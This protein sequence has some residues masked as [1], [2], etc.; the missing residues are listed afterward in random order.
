MIYARDPRASVYIY[1]YAPDSLAVE[2][3]RRARARA[4]ALGAVS[5]RDSTCKGSAVPPP[6]MELDHGL[7]TTGQR[8][9][10]HWEEA[11]LGG[12]LRQRDGQTRSKEVADDAK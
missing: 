7:G 4:L 3:S 9:H 1:P 6:Q 2:A 12:G 11:A 5:S 8:H 10:S